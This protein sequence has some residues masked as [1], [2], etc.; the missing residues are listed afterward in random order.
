MNGH[1][2]YNSLSYACKNR[3][4]DIVYFLLEKG[5]DLNKAN[6]DGDTPLIWTCAKGNGNIGKSR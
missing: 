3:N 4:E 6:K 2:N 1:D 5:V